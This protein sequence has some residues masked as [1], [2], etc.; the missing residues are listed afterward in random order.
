M[1]H[2]VENKLKKVALII[3]IIGFIISLGICIWGIAVMKY[4]LWPL[5]G[6]VGGAANILASL[7]LSWMLY[8]FAELLENVKQIKNV[9][10]HVDPLKDDLPRL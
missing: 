6:I 2:N 5:I 4:D 7:I 3:F 8:G 9:A 10:S 1:F